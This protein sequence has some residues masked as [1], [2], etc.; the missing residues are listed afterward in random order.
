M[1]PL[2]KKLGDE[3]GFTVH[4]LA[5]VSLDGQVVSSTRIREAIRAGD[6]DAAS[7]MLGRPY[8]ISGRVVE[9]DRLGRQL[10]F[11]TANLDA[12]DLILPPNGVYSGCTKSEGTIVSRRVEH[13]FASDRC[14]A[15]P[16]LRVEAHL[17]DFAG[18]LY[19]EELEVEIGENCATSRNLP[20]QRNC[21]SK[22]PATSPKCGHRFELMDFPRFQP[23]TSDFPLNSA[24]LP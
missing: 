19:G 17:L 20:R 3:I 1:S 15:R 7:Q 24:V 21:A 12:T 14:P 16:Q 13:R 4:G 6:L 22:S 23:E 2:L 11:P 5:A 10:G 9:G 18:E 8:A